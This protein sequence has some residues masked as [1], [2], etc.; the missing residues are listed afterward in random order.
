MIIPRM[1]LI[2]FALLVPYLLGVGQGAGTS[3]AMAATLPG[4]SVVGIGR[5]PGA[6][7]LVIQ[8][9]AGN[10]V[11]LVAPLVAPVAYGANIG[12]QLN[13]SNACVGG[14]DGF[15]FA[16]LGSGDFTFAT[17]K[18]QYV[19]TFAGGASVT[20]FSLVVYDWG[21]F[22]PFGR[23]PGDSCGIQMTAYDANNEIVTFDEA[24]FT[25]SSDAIT[26]RPSVPFGPLATAGDACQAALGEPG[27]AQLTVAGDGIVR[28]E[29]AFKNQQSID[30]HIALGFVRYV[31]SDDDGD[32]V[33]TSHDLCPGTPAGQ[34]VDGF[35]CSAVQGVRRLIDLANASDLADGNK[36]ALL[37]T[38]ST[39][40]VRLSD[41]N[42]ANDKAV[43][44]TV[45]AFLHKVAAFEGRGALGAD[46]ADAMRR[47]AQATL[48]LLGCS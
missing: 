41:G 35:G 43:C 34:P 17:K 14:T 45:G 22:L 36:R 6:P 7:E 2:A 42:T 47:A 16:D 27:R 31:L 38:L 46:D 25:S 23:C 8:P 11:F 39:A 5:L 21:D 48:D 26:N 19:F 32:G 24:V 30:P 13:V 40:L 29:V 15:G 20:A 37:A 18:H 33:A 12:G 1:A 44:G 28:V 3:P 10:D 9:S 4:E